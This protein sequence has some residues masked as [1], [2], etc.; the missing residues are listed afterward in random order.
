[1][2]T[3]QVGGGPG[4]CGRGKASGGEPRSPAVEGSGERAG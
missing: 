3:S 2:R 4:L 1:M